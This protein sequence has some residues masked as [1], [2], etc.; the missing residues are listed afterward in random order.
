MKKAISIQTTTAWVV[1]IAAVI[2]ATMFMTS[3]STSRRSNYQD[4]LRTAPTQ[5]W[6]RHDN[7]GCGWHN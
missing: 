1:Y 2:L 5:N 7:G 6:V 3:C 4:H